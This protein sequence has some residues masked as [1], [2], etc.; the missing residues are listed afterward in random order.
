M[1][2]RNSRGNRVPLK[3]VPRTMTLRRGHPMAARRAHNDP[4]QWRR[5]SVDFS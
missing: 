4:A 3:K 5:I 1:I 2:Y